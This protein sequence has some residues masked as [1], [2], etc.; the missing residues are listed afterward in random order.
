MHKRLLLT[1]AHWYWPRGWWSFIH[2]SLVHLPLLS[3]FR[4]ASVLQTTAAEPR[5][6]NNHWQPSTPF[7][8]VRA[9]IATA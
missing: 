3:G 2:E 8:I 1:R 9:R 7:I 4:L 6:W 5:L